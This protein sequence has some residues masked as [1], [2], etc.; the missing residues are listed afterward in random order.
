MALVLLAM[1]CIAIFLHKGRLK[2]WLR[3]PMSIGVA[4]WAAGHLLSNGKAASVVLFGSFL[5]YALL[6][7]AMNTM[8]GNMPNFLPKPRHDVISVAA[9]LVLYAFFLF[10]FHPYVLNLPIV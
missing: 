10:I 4:L 2:L 9:G 6:D 5:L 1:I 7:I 3:H 8:R